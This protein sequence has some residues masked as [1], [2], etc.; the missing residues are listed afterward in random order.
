MKRVNI[1]EAFTVPESYQ[2]PQE[3]DLIENTHYPNLNSLSYRVKVRDE[4][5]IPKLQKFFEVLDVNTMGNAV[6]VCN[7]YTGTQWNGSFWGFET[8]DDVPAIDKASYK[9]QMQSTI[10]NLKFVEAN[11]VILSYQIMGGV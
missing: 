2:Q 8:I 5:K 1:V 9:L 7:D 10:T 3:S 4:P 6:L 11:M